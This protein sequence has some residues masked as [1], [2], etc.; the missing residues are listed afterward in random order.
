MKETHTFRL[1][2]L[3]LYNARA[4]WYTMYPTDGDASLLNKKISPWE[5]YLQYQYL[6]PAS[7]HGFQGV[8]SAEVRNRALYGYTYNGIGQQNERRIFTY[9]I[10]LGARYS[11]PTYDGYF[12]HFT[13]GIRAYHGNC[14]HGQFRN[15]PSFSQVGISLIFD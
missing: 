1:G 10:F 8:A 13:M 9:N 2:L 5:L 7:R 11:T 6:S 14:P 3:L 4:G 15:L 12:S